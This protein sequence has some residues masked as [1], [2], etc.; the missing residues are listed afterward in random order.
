[1]SK[2]DRF[3]DLAPQEPDNIDAFLGHWLVKSL[4]LAFIAFAM[5]MI[6]AAFLA[7]I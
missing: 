2:R 7:A 3:P 1:M 5:C 4:S 6:A